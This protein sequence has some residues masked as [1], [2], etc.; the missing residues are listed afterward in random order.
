MAEL[1]TKRLRDNSAALWASVIIVA[2]PLVIW[3]VFL[4][5]DSVG[6]LTESVGARVSAVRSSSAPAP[7]SAQGGIIVIIERADRITHIERGQG[8]ERV[9]IENG[10][11]SKKLSFDPTIDDIDVRTDPF[12]EL[13]ST[14]YAVAGIDMGCNPNTDTEG[15]WDS[16]FDFAVTDVWFRGLPETAPGTVV[17]VTPIR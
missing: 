6:S 4:A 3:G 12:N 9:P 8:P 13:Y 11:D 5:K 17:V 14:C 15:R 7:G 1:T 2:I 16:K 10:E